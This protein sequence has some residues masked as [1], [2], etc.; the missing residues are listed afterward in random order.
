MSPQARY[1]RSVRADP[2][3]RQIQNERQNELRQQKRRFLIETE[4]QCWIY[5]LEFD[6]Q[7]DSDPQT[8]A[9]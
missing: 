4:I 7:L 3:V 1:N 6:H 9:I 5:Q 8:G 2:L